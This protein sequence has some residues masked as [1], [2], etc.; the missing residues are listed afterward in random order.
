M[1]L[2]DVFDE[3]SA[4]RATPLSASRVKAGRGA[5]RELLL[6][7]RVPWVSLPE[8]AAHAL[9]HMWRYARRTGVS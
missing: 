6:A 8:S 7:H 4:C 2:Q 3:V 9:A 1:V 5:C